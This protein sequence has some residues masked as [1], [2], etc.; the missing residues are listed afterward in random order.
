M[1][2]ILAGIRFTS[3]ISLSKDPALAFAYKNA[4]V[5]CAKIAFAISMRSHPA[6]RLYTCR[7]AI[8]ITLSAVKA[9]G[10]KGCSEKEAE[11]VSAFVRTMVQYIPLYPAV[12]HST[13]AAS[14]M[15]LLNSVSLQLL[16]L[17][18]LTY[19]EMDY[20]EASDNAK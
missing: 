18:M 13:V 8:A 15:I 5:E 3:A 10:G 19:R 6:L 17:L 16:D 7:L 11:L 1:C 14:D 12:I 9:V 2:L 4:V 20:K